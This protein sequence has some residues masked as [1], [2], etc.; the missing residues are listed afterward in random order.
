MI[1]LSIKFSSKMSDNW[2][3]KNTIHRAQ[4]DIKTS[5]TNF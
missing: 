1:I 3:K 4:S 5:P 2:E